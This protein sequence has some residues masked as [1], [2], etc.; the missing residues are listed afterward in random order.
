MQKGSDFPHNVL[1]EPPRVRFA[2]VSADKVR[3]AP[4]ADFRLNVADQDLSERLF[5]EIRTSLDAEQGSRFCFIFHTAF[6]GSTLLAGLFDQPGG[7]ITIRE[8][9]GLRDLAEIK[10]YYLDWMGLNDLQGMLETYLSALAVWAAD[11]DRILLKPSNLCNGLAHDLLGLEGKPKALLLT[12]SL[13][14]YLLACLGKDERLLKLITHEVTH[15]HRNFPHRRRYEIDPVLLRQNRLYGPAVLWHFQRLHLERLRQDFPDTSS[16][17]MDFADFRADAMAFVEK[18]SDFLA[19]PF[20][21]TVVVEAGGVHAKT[22][23]PFSA[24][25]ER[26]RRMQLAASQRGLLDAVHTVMAPLLRAFPVTA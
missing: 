15:W 16:E 8:P 25:R 14:D 19:L 24:D 23:E 21:R 5:P 10:A 2:D 12:C 18:I 17:L 11:Q 6:C 7:A 20:D 1:L 4:F 22:G 9:Q 26:E 13:E 3:Q